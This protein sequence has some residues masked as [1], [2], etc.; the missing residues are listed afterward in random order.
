MKDIFGCQCLST[1]KPLLSAPQLLFRETTSPH[2]LH[3]R[4]HHRQVRDDA[5]IAVRELDHRRV[6]DRRSA[7]RSTM[8]VL[9]ERL[10]GIDDASNPYSGGVGSVHIQ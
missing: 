5:E 1:L 10:V 2:R 7:R 8:A 4:L 9:L 3:H 6:T